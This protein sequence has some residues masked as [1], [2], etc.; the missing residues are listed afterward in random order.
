MPTFYKRKG[1]VKRG[2]WTREALE[3][4]IN[5]V[6]SGKLGV[7]RAAKE[8][9]IPQTT[10]K[11]RIKK[12]NYSESKC[13]GRSSCLGEEAENKLVLHIKKLQKSGFTPDRDS[14]R[15]M[16]FHL[17]ESLKRKHTFNRN[18]EKAGYDW[19]S[20]FLTRHPDLSIRKAEGISIA[21][22][23]GLSRKAVQGYFTLLE[24]VMSEHQL[25]D[26]P[27]NVFN[28]DESGLQLNNKPGQVIAEKGSKSVT[29]ITSG[30]KGETI[31]VIACCSA[32]GVFLPPFCIFKGKN[33]K[34]CYKD[35]MP[36][37]SAIAMNVKSAY[38]NA[39]I[40]KQ[41]LQ[42][43]FAPRKPNGPVLLILD[44]H[45]SHTNSV[46]MLEFCE[47][48][49]IVLLCLPSHTTHYL[50]PLDRSF[51][52][53]L[54]SSYYYECNR[55]IK[56]NPTKKITRYQFGKILGDSWNK[57]ATV[58]N[59]VSGFRATGIM[60]FNPDA[61]PDYAYLAE[62]STD[63][64]NQQPRKLPVSQPDHS[65]LTF[66]VTDVINSV[67]GCSWMNTDNVS[68]GCSHEPQILTTPNKY[69]PGKLLDEISPVPN[70]KAVDAVKKRSRQI[71]LILTT[72]E[73]IEEA[74]AKKIKKTK[75]QETVTLE[76]NKKQS[77]K[78][79]KK[80][81][82]RPI[83]KNKKSDT[84]SESELSPQLDS[85]SVDEWDEND[86]VG[87]G[88]NYSVTKKK[89]SWYQ[90]INCQRWSHE[91]CMK[92]TD[93]CDICGKLALKKR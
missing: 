11:N 73:N 13:L 47:K 79:D 66:A 75:K 12:K 76:K 91:G 32:E 59:A 5:A 40:F 48:N 44:G 17:A 64:T 30:E 28:V 74:K 53:S 24:S 19:L 16:A 69:T 78:N 71:A 35:G 62:P 83:K 1:T 15:S 50:Q 88:E 54:K 25:F 80:K 49:E 65:M 36:P 81:A 58:Q 8:Y 89:D 51:F 46:E 6:S 38:V 63:M 45:T 14:V 84:S 85:D 55:Y 26:K 3:N 60:P 9:G 27:G 23:E 18:K 21:R 68:P 4:A 82:R 67:P 92:Y 57:S 43:H 10:L 77:R 52:K 20:L 61:I 34:D 37:G 93:Y 41:W 87:C 2:Q 33:V 90:C 31:S 86:C 22:V 42:E 72:E 39:E 56:I 70:I 7:N 29:S